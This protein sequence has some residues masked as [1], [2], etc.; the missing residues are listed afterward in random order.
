MKM[1]IGYIIEYDLKLNPHLT[2]KFKFTEAIFTRRISNR[3]DRVYSKILACP[4]DYEEIVDTANMM[5]N[6][7]DLIIVREPFLLDDELKEKVVRWVEWAN[8]ADPKE[9]DPLFN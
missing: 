1:K 8:K 6:N 9:Y 2:E 5:K 3:G 7:S 4:V